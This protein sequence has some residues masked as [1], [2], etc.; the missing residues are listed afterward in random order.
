ME[1]KKGSKADIPTDNQ[2][3]VKRL[4]QDL[5]REFDLLLNENS[6]RKKNKKINQYFSFHFQ[7]IN[8][9]NCDVMLALF[10]FQ[11]KSN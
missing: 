3:R 6:I 11:S 7:S 10:T 1:K 4:L 9:L 2:I 5:E 8:Y